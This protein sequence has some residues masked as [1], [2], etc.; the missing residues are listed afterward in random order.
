MSQS[1]NSLS[2]SVI[3]CFKSFSVPE[4]I[5]KG[6]KKG[7]RFKMAEFVVKLSFSTIENLS[8]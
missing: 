1:S 4:K 5:N 7:E 8:R 6:E 3:F 2:P